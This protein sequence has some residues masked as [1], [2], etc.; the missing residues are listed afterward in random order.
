[1]SSHREAFEALRRGDY[2]AAALLLERAAQES[3]YASDP[4]NHAYTLA[5]YRT[6]QSARLA[7]VAFRI[8]CMMADDDPASAMDYFQRALVAGLDLE[9][10]EGIRAFQEKLAAPADARPP[11]RSGPVRKVAHVVGCLLSGHAP[12]RHIRMLTESLGHAGVESVVFTTEWAAAWFFNPDAKP[13]SDETGIHRETHVASVEGDF[14]Q[15]AGRIAEAIRASGVDAALYHANPSEQIT[16]R[17]AALRPAPIQIHVDHDGAMDLDAFDGRIHLRN[18]ASERT[19][20]AA[21]PMA[22]IPPASDIEDRLAAAKPVTRRSLGLDSA[23]SASATFGA[24]HHAS[25]PGYLMSLAEILRRFP[26]HFHIFAGSGDVKTIRPALHAAGVLPRVRFLGDMADV[27]PL[28][29]AVDVYLAPFPHSSVPFIL[30]AMGAGKPPV[31]VGHPADSRIN[32]GAEFVGIK[33]LIASNEADYVDVADRLLRSPAVR[34]GFSAAVRERFRA[35]FHPMRLGVRHAEF[36]AELAGA[37][38]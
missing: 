27:A 5:L 23:T 13:Q 25:G 16:A 14:M 11:R 10:A 8:G 30:D 24:L 19:H 3:G 33:E 17:V 2:P 31:V 35:E 20:S 36:F 21:K 26:D 6:G 4:V 15:R 34:A 29:D 22:W 9:S 7:D 1:M 37:S 32:P 12:T 38:R 28:F 18:A